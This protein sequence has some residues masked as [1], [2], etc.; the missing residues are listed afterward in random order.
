[1]FSTSRFEMNCLMIQFAKNS[2][3]IVSF[4]LNCVFDPFSIAIMQF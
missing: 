3:K 4:S 1:M 2:T